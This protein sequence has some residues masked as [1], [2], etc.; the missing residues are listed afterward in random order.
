MPAIMTARRRNR[1]IAWLG[2]LAMWFIV[3]SPIVSHG[4]ASI[5]RELPSAQTCSVDGG[6]DAEDHVAMIHLGA[7]GY[8][9]LLTH[10]VP[11]PPL[12]LPQMVGTGKYRIAQSSVPSTFV[13]GDAFS[14][15][16]PRD[17]PFLA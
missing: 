6:H 3:F 10:H 2:L 11:A 5:D 17:S 1:M 4:I 12:A 7:C 8:C 15:G 14:A 9:D 13:D 16:H